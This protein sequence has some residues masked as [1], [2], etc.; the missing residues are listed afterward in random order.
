M[1][2]F[3]DNNDAES[4]VGIV[5]R[6]KTGNMFVGGVIIKSQSLVGGNMDTG[7]PGSIFTLFL[8]F[9]YFL[10]GSTDSRILI[11]SGL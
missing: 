5:F 10:K 9:D 8:T 7:I 4:I 6:E 1:V 3:I 11:V 2:A